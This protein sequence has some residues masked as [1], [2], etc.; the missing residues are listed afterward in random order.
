M[1]DSK[2]KNTRRCKVCKEAYELKDNPYLCSKCE[3]KAE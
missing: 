1:G 3:K 2:E